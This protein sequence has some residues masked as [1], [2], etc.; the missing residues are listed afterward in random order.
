MTDRVIIAQDGDR[1]LVR[2]DKAGSYYLETV[3]PETNE[4][5]GA[6]V[7]M[8]LRMAVNTAIR[9][10]RSGATLQLNQPGL[11]RFKSDYLKRK[12]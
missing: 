10:E 3:R 9:W 8:D 4:R 6:R 1:Q 7:H 11:Q 5:L 2:Y 12:P